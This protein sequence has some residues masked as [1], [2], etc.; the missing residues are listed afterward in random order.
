MNTCRTSSSH[1]ILDEVRRADLGGERG[2]V[3]RLVAL[4]VWVGLVKNVDSFDLTDAIFAVR[5]HPF[6]MFL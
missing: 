2:S 4:I 6:F 5:L 3:S 1:S